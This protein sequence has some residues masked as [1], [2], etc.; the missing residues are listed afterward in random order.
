M[1]LVTDNVEELAAA[2]GMY[3]LT[4][5]EKMAQGNSMANLIIDEFRV[6]W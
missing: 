1:V 4:H 3:V 5:P 2:G 6:D